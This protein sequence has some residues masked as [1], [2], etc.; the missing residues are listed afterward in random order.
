MTTWPPLDA[1]LNNLLPHTDV[2]EWFLVLV[3]PIFL[4]FVAIEWWHMRRTGQHH[5]HNGQDMMTSINLGSVY[6]LVDV[7][8]LYVL[9]L[10]AMDWLYQHRWFTIDISV[11]SFVALF[12]GVEFLYYWFHRAS[13]RIRWFWC[14]HVAHHASEYMNFTTALRQSWLYAVAG[15]WLFYTPMVLLGFEPR[16]VMFA[17]ALSLFYQFFVHTQ[18]VK[19]LPRPIEFVFNTPS[20]HRVHHGRN[21]AYIDKNYGGV[22][23]I[24]D[25]LFGTFEPEVEAPDYGLVHPMLSHNLIWL[26]IHEWVAM[27]RD[28]LRPAP[29]RVRLKC[30][31]GPPG[32]EP[33][34]KD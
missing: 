27:L 25:R 19:H 10:P 5:I 34:F 30:I 22:L 17:Y 9:V 24:F 3:A 23:I 11:G 6:S 8:M 14:A 1:L 15:N 33:P 29:W 18:W 20:H 21:P 13:H 28:V 26:T 2:R 31:W 16:W 7:L 12:L 32:W 4:L